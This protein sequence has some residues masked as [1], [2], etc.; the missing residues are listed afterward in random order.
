MKE[1]IFTGILHV[2]I[3][4]VTFW[5]DGNRSSIELDQVK[6]LISAIWNH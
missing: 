4:G 3:A 1:T 6:Q 5:L 2:I